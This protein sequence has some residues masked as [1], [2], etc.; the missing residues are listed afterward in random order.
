MTRKIFIYILL[1]A[2]AVSATG[3]ACP[4]TFV[5]LDTLVQEYN[6]NAAAVPRL[7]ARAK[8]AVTITDPDSGLALTWG[9]A[10]PAASPNS[11]LVL[12]KNESNKL[13][14]HDFAII[15]KE[16]GQTIFKLGSSIGQQV[17]YFWYNVGDNGEAWVGRSEFAG[18]PGVAV[19]LDPNQLLAVLAV[20]ELPDDFTNIPTAALTMNSEPCAYVLTYIDRQPVSN[21]ILFTRRVYFHWSDTLPRRPYR[22]EFFDADGQIVM[23]AEMKDYQP[24]ATTEGN[25]K[26]RPVMP[27]DIKISWPQTKTEIHMVLSD[28]TTEDKWDRDIC[29]PKIPDT[30]RDRIIDVDRAVKPN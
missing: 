27:T 19:P 29:N 16:M 6:A 18:A 30:I 17:Y 8:I 7:W 1:A 26:V 20:C 4:D 5:S 2:A 9:S 3:C 12:G 14:P 15:G 28:M 21:R 11:W 10:S 25:D 24:V 22:A 23:H 13:G